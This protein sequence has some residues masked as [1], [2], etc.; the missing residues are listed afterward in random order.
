MDVDIILY[1]LSEVTGGSLYI[2]YC[3]LD[4]MD[5]NLILKI[6]QEF[7][8]EN[9]MMITS[10]VIFFLVYVYYRVRVVQPPVIHC[11]DNSR[12]HR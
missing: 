10:L 4:E 12:L 11:R 2:V 7:Y 5:F 3:N 8:D 6:C 1:Y 9:P